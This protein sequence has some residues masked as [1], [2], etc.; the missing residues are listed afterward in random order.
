MKGDLKILSISDT[1]LGLMIDDYDLQ[2]DIERILISFV[3][4]GAK[5]KKQ[6][7][8]VVLI[9]GGDIFESSRPTEANIGALLRVLWYIKKYELETYFIVGNHEATSN[10]KRVS[11]LSFIKDVKRAY[12]TIKLIEGYKHLNMGSYA[13][14]DVLFTFLPHISGAYLESKGI[15]QTPQEYVEEKCK[16]VIKKTEGFMGDHYVFSHLNVKGA[17][18]GSEELLMKKS[19]VYLPACM[20]QGVFMGCKPTIIQ[21]H[22]HE[23]QEQGNLKIVGNPIRCA[24][25]ETGEK[26]YQLITVP[27]EMG[28]P[29]T[30]EYIDTN[31]PSFNL[32]ELDLRGRNEDFF[33]TKEMKDFFKTVSEQDR[34]ILKVDVTITPEENN[35]DWKL[36][37][38]RIKKKYPNCV[39]REIVPRLI[40]KRVARN[41]KQKIGIPA[42]KAMKIFVLNNYKKDIKLAKSIFKEGK[43]YL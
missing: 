25:N 2:D 29:Q 6:G 4:H 9:F 26:G 3:R 36:I 5:L 15:E 35:Y 7:F 28:N 30:F 14:G 27:I 21:Y 40:T 39:M 23:R 41:V 1:H 19:N 43:K 37:R 18:G 38:K 11:S 16:L 34:F 22:I 33:A 17:H 12:P 10:P 31:P 8:R 20:T 13:N 42:E 24:V 32:V